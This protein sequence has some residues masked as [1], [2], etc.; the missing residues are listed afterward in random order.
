MAGRVRDPDF[1]T[2][3]S[4]H[5]R[6]ARQHKAKAEVALQ[7]MSLYRQKLAVERAME[8][9]KEEYARIRDGK[10]LE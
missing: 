1:A 7:L 10:C 2:L 3:R 5:T 4:G 8:R 6:L 9:V